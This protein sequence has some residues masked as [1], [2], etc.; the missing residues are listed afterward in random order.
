MKTSEYVKN[1]KSFITN[2][3]E[4]CKKASI[5]FRVEEFGKIEGKIGFK[6]KCGNCT[7]A[8][9]TRW[10]N[11]FQM[12]RFRCRAWYFTERYIQCSHSWRIFVRPTME[13]RSLWIQRWCVCLFPGRVRRTLPSRFGSLPSVPR[14]L[15]F[16]Q[17]R[18]R[19]WGRLS[20]WCSQPTDSSRCR[21]DTHPAYSK[22]I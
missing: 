6:S 4:Q 17:V 13:S 11:E 9:N 5:K 10:K 16:G 2:Y 18:L 15:R 19:H 21:L 12:S 22:I 7:I 20:P 14:G 3:W 1:F 8:K